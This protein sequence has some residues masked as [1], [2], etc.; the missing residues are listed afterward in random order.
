MIIGVLTLE[1]F[2]PYARSLKDKRQT[3]KGFKDRIRKRYNAAVAELDFQDK[4]QRTSI[5]VVTLN[6][7]LRMVEDVLNRVLSDAFDLAD[8]EIADHK[9]RYF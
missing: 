4:W 9:I 1:I 6:S 3:V 7:Q 5:G 8:C 2:L